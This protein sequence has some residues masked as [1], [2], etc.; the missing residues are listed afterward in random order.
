MDLTTRKFG[1]SWFIPI[2]SHCDWLGMKSREIF[3][4]FYSHLAIAATHISE[5]LKLK[6]HPT[7]LQFLGDDKYLL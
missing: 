7:F 6:S 5:F 4:A 1:S 2:Q 3:H